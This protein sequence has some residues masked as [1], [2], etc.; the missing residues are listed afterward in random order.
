MEQNVIDLQKIEEETKVKIAA[1]NS[2]K[3]AL[4]A[5]F[6]TQMKVWINDLGTKDLNMTALHLMYFCAISVFIA[7]ELYLVAGIMSN[8]C[9]IN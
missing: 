8:V 2:Q 5:A 6:I 3:V 4:V 9:L 7:L 1:V